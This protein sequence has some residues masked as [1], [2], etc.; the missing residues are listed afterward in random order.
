ME[1]SF[2]ESIL[3]AYGLTRENIKI[4]QRGSGLINGTYLLTNLATAE[5]FVL[6]YLNSTACNTS[7]RYITSLYFNGTRR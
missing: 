2:D 6:Q 1:L 5:I 4:Q 3:K 7:A